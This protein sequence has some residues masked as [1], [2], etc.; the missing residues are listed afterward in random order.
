MEKDYKKCKN[1]KAITCY[2]GYASNYN[3][4]IFE[5]L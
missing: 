4:E 5:L 1:N 3:V 2:K